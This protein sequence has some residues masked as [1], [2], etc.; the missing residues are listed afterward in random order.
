MKKEELKATGIKF[1]EVDFY[2]NGIYA[3]TKTFY[4][5]DD[6]VYVTIDYDNQMNYNGENTTEFIC[7]VDRIT[8]NYVCFE[9]GMSENG[10]GELE[11]LLMKKLS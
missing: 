3:G 11:F 4:L 7:D 10:F 9:C 5:L 1:D 2:N 8:K 6:K